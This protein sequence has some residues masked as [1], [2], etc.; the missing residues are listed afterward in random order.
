MAFTLCT[1]H[2]AVSLYIMLHYISVPSGQ[3][4]LNDALSHAVVLAPSCSFHLWS[5][6]RRKNRGGGESRAFLLFG[7]LVFSWS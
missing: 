7:L 6:E 2:F 4:V 5:L 1:F 3:L